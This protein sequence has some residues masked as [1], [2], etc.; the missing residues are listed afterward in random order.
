MLIF[1]FL[2]LILLRV[3]PVQLNETDI[4]KLSPEVCFSGFGY[5]TFCPHEWHRSE[6]SVLLHSR[7]RET[8]PTRNA[9]SQ[10]PLSCIPRRSRQPTN[11]KLSIGQIEPPVRD[12]F[13]RYTANVLNRSAGYM[14]Y[15]PPMW[16]R[17]LADCEMALKLDPIYTK[18]LNRRAEALEAMDQLEDALRGLLFVS[19]SLSFCN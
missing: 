18:A 19:I 3:A 11:L 13:L 17:V 1:V 5:I 10:R 14:N 12:P 6:I 15:S 7:R 8:P 9:N 2:L 16:D 4:E